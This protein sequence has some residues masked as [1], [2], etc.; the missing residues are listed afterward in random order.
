MLRNFAVVALLALSTAACGKSPD[1]V[2]SKF[3]ELEAKSD[4]K[5]KKTPGKDE[6]DK[7]VKELTEM[8]EVSPEAYKCVVGCTEK[9]TEDAVMGCVLGCV[10]GDEKLKAASEKKSAKEKEERAG[11]LLKIAD[12]PS[13]SFDGKI[14]TF[15]DKTLNF[16]IS[17]GEGFAEDT[18]LASESMKSY[19]LKSEDLFGPSVTISSGFDTDL[20]K[21]VKQAGEL[22]EKVI[23]QEKT[24]KGYI[25]STESDG[26][27]KAEVLVKSGESVISCRANAFG[28]E[29]VKNK[30][31]F[32][33]W[34]EKM[35]SSLAIK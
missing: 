6:H 32:L 11:K 27:I 7:C 28:D 17:L 31:K 14:K 26:M 10:L 8:K 23:K 1:A 30:D 34:L 13:K 24:D 35:C 21:A 33:P 9:D 4:K 25:L 12:A 22:K 16:S 20:D 29:Y 2:C 3:E 19:E 15:D 5:D 18:K